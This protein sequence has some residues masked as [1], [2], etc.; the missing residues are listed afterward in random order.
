M[1]DT[2][3]QASD[4]VV[5]KDPADRRKRVRGTIIEVNFGRGCTLYRV[6]LDDDPTPMG[7]CDDEIVKTV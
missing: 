3:Y 6:V 5:V 2:R 1:S 7:F 4:R